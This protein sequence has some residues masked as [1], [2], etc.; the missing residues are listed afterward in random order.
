MI[1]HKTEETLVRIYH[2]PVCDKTFRAQTGPTISRCAV[3]HGPGSCCH[4]GEQEVS[5]AQLQEILNVLKGP[6]L[7]F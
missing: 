3:F 4:H 1:I 7:E 6:A 5:T 2:C